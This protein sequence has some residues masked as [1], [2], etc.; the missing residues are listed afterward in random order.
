MYIVMGIKINIKDRRGLNLRSTFLLRKKRVMTFNSA[1]IS[2]IR[3]LED[4]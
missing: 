2:V 4:L 1:H 3:T